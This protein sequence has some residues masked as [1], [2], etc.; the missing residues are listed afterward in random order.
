MKGSGKT[1]PFA[2]L[3][4]SYPSLEIRMLT[5]LKRGCLLPPVSTTMP[6]ESSRELEADVRAQTRSKNCR[7]QPSCSVLSSPVC[8]IDGI[9]VSIRPSRSARWRISIE[10]R[11]VW[12]LRGG[13][14][15]YSGICARKQDRESWFGESNR[16]VW[17]L[18]L[19]DVG[20][21]AVKRPDLYVAGPKGRGSALR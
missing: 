13:R 14:S 2:I 4:S 7:E 11:P 9:V 20:G 17:L 8:S 10:R 19:Q 6:D 3:Y 15:K 12:T 16:C 18:P 5:V 1:Y 21:A